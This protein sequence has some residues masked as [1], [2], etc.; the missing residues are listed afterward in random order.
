[1]KN[2]AIIFL[3][4]LCFA[5]GGNETE[6]KMDFSNITFT[7]DTVVVD[8]G[9]EILNL[10]YG[11]WSSTMTDDKGFLYLWNMDESTLDKVNINE[12]RLEEKIKY[13][14]EGPD[15][16]GT[17]VSWM[18]MLDN[19]QILM[20]NFQGMGLFDLNGKKLRNYKLEKEKFEGDSLEEG[21]SFNRKSIITDGGNVIYGLL[22]NWMNDNLSFAKVNFQDMMIKKYALPG[23][24]ELIDYSVMLKSGQMTMISTTDKTVQRIGDKIILSNSAYAPIFVFDMKQDSVYQVNYTPQLTAAAKKGGYPKE[25][26]S[27]KRFKEVMAEIKSEINFQAPVW[28]EVNKRFYRFSYETIPGEIADEPMLEDTEQIPI[29]KVFISIFDEDFN[30]IGESM[31]SQLTQIPNFVFVKDGKIWFYVNVDD[32]LGF[33]RMEIKN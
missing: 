6:T 14:K 21:E 27:E 23:I 19:D 30:L 26:D 32:E 13:E 17:Y 25:V 31:V 18:N 7:M 12:L 3:S 2:Y 11:L 15:G 16:V 29:S 5:C 28:D 20:A 9:N 24:E 10:K 4:V 1:M 8:P 22:G 33:V